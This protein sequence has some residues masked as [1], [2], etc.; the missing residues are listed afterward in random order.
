MRILRRKTVDMLSGSVVKGLLSMAIPI[1]IMNVMQNMFSVIDMTVLG[2]LV[3]DRAVGAVG[4]CGVL[5]TLCTGLFIGT[6]VGANVVV[7]KH[8]GEGDRERT[9]KAIGT[10]LAFAIISGLFLS[11]IGVSCA[12]TFLGWTNCPEGLLAD[13]VTYFRIY[14]LGVPIVL[15]YNFAAAVL[16]AS[17]DTQR[18]MYF[19]LLGGAVKVV[20]NIFCITV[21]KM[22]VA[23]V[24]IA[25]IIS[26]GIAGSLCI[27]AIIKS[28][29]KFDFE[30]K[31]TK[32]DLAELRQIL[33]IGIP[34]G[35][36]Q[37]LYSFA[38]VIIVSTVNGFG[39]AATT[40][41]S[42]ANQFDGIL[43]QIAVAPSLAVTPYVSQN[44]G[45]GNLKRVKE[46][47][48]KGIL[49]T[50]AFGAT[51]GALSAIFSGQLASI[52]TSSPEVIRYSQQKMMLVSSTYFI[53]GINEL[54][55]G[56]LKGMGKPII[57]TVTTMIFMCGIRFPWVYF[58]F[59][60]FPHLTF[61]YLIWPI[62]WMLS[63]A[64]LLVAYFRAMS[65]L[66]KNTLQNV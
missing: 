12:E 31:Q 66:N 19:L 21:L 46:S 28:H 20:L 61:L 56:T 3:N 29:D 40:G 58:V 13:A 16:R 50:T 52:M 48:V 6:A 36:Q 55:G 25:T 65:K 57:P 24:A 47:I 27:N 62:G 30:L 60:L 5:I 37:A 44:M 39:E 59:P 23:G 1:M 41:V 8:I 45:A 53:C 35:L 42:I 34:T 7:A 26:T 18:P 64:T 51:F 33:F 4:A 2:N 10:S 38:N 22:T 17:G 14:F 15:L 9:Q 32:I 49:I 54:V 63:I 11:V 43:Y